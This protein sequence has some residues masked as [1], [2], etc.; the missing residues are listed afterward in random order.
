MTLDNNFRNQL[1]QC[2]HNALRLVVFLLLLL[3]KLLSVLKIKQTVFYLLKSLSIYRRNLICTPYSKV[4]YSN[5]T[6]LCLF[7]Y[8]Y[9]Q[10]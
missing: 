10:L 4:R 2:I 1:N 5:R 3:E 9:F 6:I 8:E 7:R